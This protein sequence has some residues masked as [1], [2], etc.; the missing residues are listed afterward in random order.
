VASTSRSASSPP[1]SRTEAST[2]A[3]LCLALAACGGKDEGLSRAQFAREANSICGR[4]NETVRELGPE[5]PILTSE[6]A[7]WI[8]KLTRIDRATL[9]DL[10]AL[11]PPEEERAAIASMLAL[12]GRGLARGEAIARASRAGNDPV[13]RRNVDAALASFA[14]ARAYAQRYGLDECALLGQVER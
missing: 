2:A 4:G 13:F 5:P 6:Q 14:G 7:H 8:L 1:R 11:E 9:G 10:R 3:L 12:F